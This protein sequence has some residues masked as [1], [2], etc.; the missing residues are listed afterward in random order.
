MRAFG[1]EIPA[2][3]FDAFGRPRL[4][5][6]LAGINFNTTRNTAALHAC[7]VHLTSGALGLDPSPIIGETVRDALARFAA[8]V[9]SR[10]VPSFPDPIPDFDGVGAPF[11]ADRI[12]FHDLE[13]PD[14]VDACRARIG[15]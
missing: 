10:G 9:R 4:E 12:P 3:P 5:L 14:A 13:L 2:I 1:V 15:S 7:A 11:P 8:C 6:S